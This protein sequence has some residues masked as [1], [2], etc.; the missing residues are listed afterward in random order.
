MVVPRCG[1]RSGTYLLMAVAVDRARARRYTGWVDPSVDVIARDNEAPTAR[2][3]YTEPPL[4]PM[5]F[6]EDVTGVSAISAAVS[7]GF[8]TRSAAVTGEWTCSDAS[9]A[10]VECETGTVRRA[11]FRP[12]GPVVQ[13]QYIVNLNPNQ[14]LDIRDASG[15]PM[16]RN[17]LSLGTPQG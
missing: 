16:A 2:A 10:A 15:N 5:A 11:Q 9:G 12:T 13:D 6:S 4:L 8:G 17:G 1:T 3:L 7:V 14:V